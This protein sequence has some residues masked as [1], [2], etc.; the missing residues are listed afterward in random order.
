MAVSGFKRSGSN[1]DYEGRCSTSARPIPKRL[2]MRLVG[3]EGLKSMKRGCDP[4]L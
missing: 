2:E 1:R 4:I 3:Q